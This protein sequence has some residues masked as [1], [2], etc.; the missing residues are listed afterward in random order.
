MNEVD[1]ILAV[2]ACLDASAPFNSTTHPLY[3]AVTFV[4]DYPL[5]DLGLPRVGF[6]P[7]GGANRGR[8]L[9]TYQRVG[10]PVYQVD[11]LSATELEARRIFQGLRTALQAD[12]E[13]GDSTDADTWGD[14][15]YGYLKSRLI[16]SAVLSEPSAAVWDDAGRVGRVTATLTLEY[17]EE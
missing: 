12:Y 7:A 16:K 6:S 17:L 10:Q 14:P 15:G 13:N 5:R 2:I 8:G 11:V 3:K 1:A 9:G 4:P